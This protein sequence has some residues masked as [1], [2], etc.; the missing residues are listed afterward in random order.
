MA[1]HPSN[2][3]A[4]RWSEFHARVPCG[5]NGDGAIEKRGSEENGGYAPGKQ[6][7]GTPPD[8]SKT[9]LTGLAITSSLEGVS[10]G[11]GVGPE[12]TGLGDFASTT[13]KVAVID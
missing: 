4:A 2:W 3:S 11:I 13:N 9:S 5:L 7:F 12:D 6:Y 1:V 10:I 8:K